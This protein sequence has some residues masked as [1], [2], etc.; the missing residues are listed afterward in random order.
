[1][2]NKTIKANQTL[3]AHSICDHNCVFSLKV[4]E[5]NGNFAVIKRGGND[6]ERKKIRI[7]FEGN[8]YVKPD[9]YSFAPMFRAI[10]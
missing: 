7:D 1:M 5:R 8:E 10:N 9:G 4:I 6:I 2:A 3:T